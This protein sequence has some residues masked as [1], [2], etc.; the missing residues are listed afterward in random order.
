MAAQGLGFDIGAALLGG[1]IDR[2]GARLE[3][4]DLGSKINARKASTQNALAQARLRVDEADARESLAEQLD[5]GGNSAIAA[6][7]RAGANP[8]QVTGAQLGQQEFG[9]R[10]GITDVDLPFEQ[11]QAFAQG[12]EGKVVDPF[13]IS[14]GLFADVFNPGDAPQLAATNPLDDEADRALAEQRRASGR[15]SDER[16][17]HPER[18]KS[19]TTVNVNAAGEGLGDQILNDIGASTIPEDIKP[20]TATG[21]T[22][23]LKSVANTAF[24]VV[25]ANIPFADADRAQNALT[26]LHTRTQIVG[27]QSVPGRPSNYLMQQLA[28]FGVTPNDVFRSDQRSLS[29]LQ[30]T[31]A[32]F[33]GEIDRLR[34]ILNAGRLTP[35]RIADHEDAL[36]SLASLKQDFDVVISRFNRDESG[37][38]DLSN[39]EVGQTVTI[40]GVTVTR[41]D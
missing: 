35:T 13:Q 19:S 31:S 28:T 27:Q 21:V 9:F 3:G 41:K 18:F 34:R 16:R 17:L 7:V 22:G 37:G 4:L 29:R 33:G 12:V 6:S 38:A 32:F 5:L 25:N 26:D 24:D 14:G 39:V 15:L 10:E 1:D 11:R 30:Q 40:N 2:E 36:R 20:E 8:E 23:A